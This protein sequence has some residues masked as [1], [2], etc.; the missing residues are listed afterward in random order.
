MLASDAFADEKVNP[1]ASAQF[2]ETRSSINEVLNTS[3]INME[4]DVF[5]NDLRQVE[6][7]VEKENLAREEALRKRKREEYEE[8]RNKILSEKLELPKAP[9]KQTTLSFGSKVSETAAESTTK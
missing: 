4:D 8:W 2:E 6:G 7:I 5:A 3:A 9:T 1:D